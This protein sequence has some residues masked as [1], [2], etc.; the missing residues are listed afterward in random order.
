MSDHNILNREHYQKVQVWVFPRFFR[1]L[2]LPF[3]TRASMYNVST[4]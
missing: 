3:Q 1:Q 2:P 4:N